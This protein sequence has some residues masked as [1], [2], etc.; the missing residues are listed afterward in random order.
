MLS[1]SRIVHYFQKQ[2]PSCIGDDAAVLPFSENE[3][4]IIT[5]DLLVEDLHFRRKYT[6][7]A[8]L[9]HKALHVNLSDLAAMG[10]M[11]KYVLL[12][13]S[14]PEHDANYINEFLKCFAEV[15]KH[16]GVVLIGGDTTKSPN[17]LFISI[18]AIGTAANNHIKYRNNAAIGDLICVAGDLG[19]AH[20]GLTLL[21]RNIPGFN[22]FKEKC[23]K[24]IARINEGIWFGK[25]FAVT[26][27]MDISDGCYIDLKR[28]C[29]SS[30]TL[31]QV[32]L[33]SL[34]PTQ[35]FISVCEKLGLDP[36]MTELTGGEDYGLI[37][38]IKPHDY[39]TI[40]SKF[41]EHFGYKLKVIGK[42]ME[43]EGINFI[44]NGIHKTLEL[45]PFSHFGEL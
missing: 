8:S 28:L 43:G 33:D 29:E 26:A 2:F 39:P 21:E 32:N 19:Y 4:Y 7:A 9:A 6:D 14:I 10:A 13:I 41:L 31:A 3:S 15:C 25:E 23:L 24:P 20:L 12:G 18:T 45:Q 36:L 11:P 42:M 27:M 16:C 37:M 5:K 34:E 38:T 40:S 1:E 30:H 35:E 44:K 17:K 22:Q